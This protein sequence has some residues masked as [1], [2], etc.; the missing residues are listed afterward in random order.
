MHFQNLKTN[1]LKLS[2]S[3]KNLA[4]LGDDVS[5]GAL[6]TVGNELGTVL[7]NVSTAFQAGVAKRAG[8]IPG[9][10]TS[11]GKADAIAE[12]L[13]AAADQIGPE[14]FQQMDDAIQGL[15]TRMA[16]DMAALGDEA[17]LQSLAG[18]G[19]SIS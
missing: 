14:N 15:M 17:S 3:F 7:S 1:S 19:N 9:F 2:D 8:V 4:K 5:G 10:V 16:S 6:T 13:Q 18:L 12:A 11:G